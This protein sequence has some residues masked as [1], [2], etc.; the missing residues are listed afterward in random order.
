MHNWGKLIFLLPLLLG[1]CAAGDIPVSPTAPPPVTLSPPPT[2]SF[3]GVCDNTHQLEAWLQTTSLLLAD[4][5]SQ[6]NTA[7][8]QNRSEVALSVVNL[9]RLRDSAS[10]AAAPDCA[11]DQQL[12]ISDAMNKAVT[13][14]QTFANGGQADVGGTVAAVNTEIDQINAAQKT[15][16]QRM[17]D[18]YRQQAQTPSPGG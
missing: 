4:F 13:V 10:T 3:A 17:D 11:A 6:M 18:Q 5:Q 1:A 12:K 8:A 2:L 7:A 14:L 16:M 15:L 9:A